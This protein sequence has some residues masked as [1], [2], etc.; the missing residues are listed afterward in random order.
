MIFQIILTSFIILKVS[1]NTNEPVKNQKMID[2]SFKS[3]KP[4]WDYEDDASYQWTVIEEDIDTFQA[5]RQHKCV[6]DI[7]QTVCLPPPKASKRCT[8]FELLPL[9]FE[10]EKLFVIGH[11]V[12][13]NRIAKSS[14]YVKDMNYLVA[15]CFFL[16]YHF[17]NYN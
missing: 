8:G 16:Y 1:A 13:R 3:L 9:T 17:F 2:F 15:T 10:T 14:L 6:E 7:E 12:L 5:C 11:N 4:Y